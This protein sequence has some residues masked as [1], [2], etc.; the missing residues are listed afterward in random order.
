MKL[1]E[2]NYS[3][4]EKLSEF[5]NWLGETA[6][7]ANARAI[8]LRNIRT[9]FNYA[10]A[11]EYTAAPY[12]FRRFKIQTA[13]TKDR[14][15]PL[16]ELRLLYS[17]PCTDTQRKYRDIF[18]LSFF[19][20]GLNLED[21]LSIKELH[22]GRVETLRKKTGQPISIAV[23]PEAMEIIERYKGRTR[24]LDV[25]DKCK[26]YLNYLH[27]LNK[28]L[29]RIGMSYN[30][31]TKRW[32]GRSLFPEISYYYARYSW[33]TLAAELDIPERTI[34]AAL[35]HSTAKSVT[36]RY[37]RVDMRKKIDAA[38]RKVLDF[39]LHK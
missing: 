38:N 12:P 4:D 1:K 26:N 5:D 8:H 37:T 35:G 2:Y 10:I 15:I 36:S 27:R 7:S 13:P 6:K 9:V 16:E 23:P 11:E 3:L 30:A 20:C 25:S 32:E 17:C 28:V 19:L 21:L 22:G 34:G 31:K 24:L 39:F 33:A 18:F 14:S 29:K